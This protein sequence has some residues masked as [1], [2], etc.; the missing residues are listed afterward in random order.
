M[1]C[2]KCNSEHIV[3][4]GKTKGNNQIFLCRNCKKKFTYLP[5]K[6]CEDCGTQIDNYENGNKKLCGNCSKNHKRNYKR[7]WWKNTREIRNAKHRDYYWDN[8]SFRKHRIEQFKL[9]NK[10][11]LGV[12]GLGQHLSNHCGDVD[13]ELEEKVVKNEVDRIFRYGTSR[14]NRDAVRWAE[15]KLQKRAL[16]HRGI[17]YLTNIALCVIDETNTCWNCWYSDFP[18]GQNEIGLCS[19]GK[20]PNG[21]YDHTKMCDE[22]LRS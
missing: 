3:K 9:I 18:F 4:C 1:K 11:R 17:W 19:L 20:H 6:S 8:S 13:F 7:K 21:I 16:G 15:W 5:P 2:I 22:M 14:Y 12:S 10:N